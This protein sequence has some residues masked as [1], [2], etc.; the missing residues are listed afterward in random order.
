LNQANT[1]ETESGVAVVQGFSC[2]DADIHANDVFFQFS[3]ADE[4]MIQRRSIYWGEKTMRRADRR[5]RRLPD[6]R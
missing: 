2:V 1:A 4:A 6:L 5:R 3:E